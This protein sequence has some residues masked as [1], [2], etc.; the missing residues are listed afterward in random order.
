MPKTPRKSKEIFYIQCTFLLHKNTYLDRSN[1][2]KMSHIQTFART[3]TYFKS[4]QKR[5]GAR[6]LLVHVDFV[7]DS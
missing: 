2:P 7:S 1:S 6:M 3:C 5:N 4:Y